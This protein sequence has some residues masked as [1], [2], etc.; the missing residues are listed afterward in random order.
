MFYTESPGPDVRFSKGG[1]QLIVSPRKR[2]GWG[3]PALG[4]ML[5]LRRGR[6]EGV[7][8]TPPP[9]PIR[10]WSCTMLSF[11][12]STKATNDPEM[13]RQEMKMT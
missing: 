3:D 5:S 8:R 1:V 12:N 11:E 9:P 6:K 13:E 2:Q 7:P 4:P 10:H